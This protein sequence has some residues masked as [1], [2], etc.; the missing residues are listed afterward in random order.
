MPGCR[1][2]FTNSRCPE[3]RRHSNVADDERIGFHA[4]YSTDPDPEPS[5]GQLAGQL[6]IEDAA[7]SGQRQQQASS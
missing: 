6:T 7:V 3:K 1:L 4:L 2:P 5:P